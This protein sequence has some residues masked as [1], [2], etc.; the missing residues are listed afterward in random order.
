MELSRFIARLE[1]YADR[2]CLHANGEWSRYSQLLAA[3]SRWEVRLSGLGLQRGSVI[4]LQSDFGLEAVGLLLAAWRRRHVVA[5]VPLQGDVEAPLA[6]ANACGAWCAGV[7]GELSWRPR[8]AGEESP[9]V[10][11]LR[12]SGDAGVVI[13]TSG[14]SGA[15]KAA[16]HEVERFL[17]K[18]AVPGRALRTLGFLLFDHVGGLDTLLYTLSAGGS[19]VT[20]ARRDPRS[21]CALIERTGVEVLPAS[22]SFLRLLCLS[23]EAVRHDLR[24]LAIITYGA[25]PMDPSTLARVNET[26]PGVRISQK[27]GTTET[28]APRTVSRGS[29]SLW[30][31]LGGAGVETRIDPGG[32]LWIRGA[33]TLLGYLNAAS[34]IDSDGWF[35]TGDLVECDGPW[36]RILGRA[37]DVI[38]VGG[39]KVSPADVERVILELEWVA[40]ASVSGQSHP[41]MGQVVTARVSLVEGTDP[42]AAER[43]VRRHC[44]ERL[45]RYKVPVTVDV[46]EGGLSSMRQK[47]VRN[48][49]ARP[50]ALES[51]DTTERSDFP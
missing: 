12:D 7:V 51:S 42:A 29:D 31:Q 14:S 44:L 20:T 6:A 34:P 39:E 26:F 41:L 3:V 47:L 22:P 32:V 50:V 35:C 13:F 8:P 38:N 1:Q 19:L 36:L 28:G 43:R 2:P 48:V 40:A 21:V 16:L 25:E 11:Q 10:S 24:S 46:A 49:N 45:P 23:G 33:G 9:L 15:A 30:V 17:A 5:L 37:S 18:F 27:Y 4:G